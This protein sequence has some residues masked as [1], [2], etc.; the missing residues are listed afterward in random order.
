MYFLKLLQYC[1][2][3]AEK[4]QLFLSVQSDLYDIMF[5]GFEYKEQVT[6]CDP[7]DCKIPLCL[8]ERSSLAITHSPPNS[9]AALLMH[10]STS[11]AGSGAERRGKASCWI[12]VTQ[13]CCQIRSLSGPVTGA[14]APLN[15]GRGFPLSAGTVTL[16]TFP[17]P[18]RETESLCRRSFLQSAW[19]WENVPPPIHK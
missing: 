16:E 13:P 9:F 7:Y 19:P 5:N 18:R 17:A 10:R 8:T 1:T 14:A 11:A 4:P 2:H 6:T 12:S 15:S 3:V